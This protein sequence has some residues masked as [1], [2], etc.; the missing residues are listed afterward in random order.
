MKLPVPMMLPA[1]MPYFFRK[2]LRDRRRLGRQPDLAAS[3]RSLS[4]ASSAASRTALP[5]WNS[6]REPSVAMSYGVTS[7]SGCTIVIDSTGRLRTSATI[8]AMAVS[9][10]CPMSTV[11]Q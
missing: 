9:E 6:E 4:R 8:C 11:L 7:V 10:P 5:M 2:T 3:A 1:C